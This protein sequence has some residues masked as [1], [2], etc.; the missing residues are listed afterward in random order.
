VVVLLVTDGLERDPT[1]G[2]GANADHLHRSGRR[3]VAQPPDLALTEY[4]AALKLAPANPDALEGASRA[5]AACGDQ[6]RSE[7]YRLASRAGREPWPRAIAVRRG[8]TYHLAMRLIIVGAG[9]IGG[10]LA[11]RL[12]RAGREA[13]L[14]ARGA[15]LATLRRASTSTWTTSMSAGRRRSRTSPG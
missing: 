15:Q 6:A 11:G 12:A 3:I 1:V 2:L 14:I 13:L 10:V 7:A 9:A 4:E 8:A 5:A